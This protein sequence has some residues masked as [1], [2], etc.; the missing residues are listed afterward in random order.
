MLVRPPAVLL[1]LLLSATAA[2]Q[3]AAGA[4]GAG[5]LPEGFEVPRPA[6]V[7]E[8]V[9]PEAARQAGASGVVHLRLQLGEDGLVADVEVVDGPGHGLEAAAVDAAR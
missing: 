7:V 3:P 8:P 1:L 9:I 4:P 6:N 5:A 2:A